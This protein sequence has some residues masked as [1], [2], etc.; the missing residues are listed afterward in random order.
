MTVVTVLALWQI[1]LF[2]ALGK[3][4]KSMWPLLNTAQFIIYMSLWQVNY[5]DGLRVLFMTLRKIA[6]AEF[7]D[8][9]AISEKFNSAFG[10]ST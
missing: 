1:V 9:L 5:S 3:A 10:I 4:L 6:F 2:F 8:D 7:M